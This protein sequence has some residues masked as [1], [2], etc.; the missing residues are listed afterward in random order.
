[1][2]W[3][4]RRAPPYFPYGRYIVLTQLALPIGFLAGTQVAQGD[5]N[6]LGFVLWYG[7]I[8]AAV[9]GLLVL[10]PISFLFSLPGRETLIVLAWA[11]L[12]FEL[13]VVGVILRTHPELSPPFLAL[14]KLA[15]ALTPLWSVGLFFALGRRLLQ[16]LE[17]RHIFRPGLPAHARL[18]L[19]LVLVIAALPLGG[20]AI[21]FWMCARQGLW[22]RYEKCPAA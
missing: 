11:A 20:V 21:P 12:H 3:L 6:G 19:A 7:G 16:P 14:F 22:P 2:G 17:L 13:F 8:A 4:R 1:V 18:V 10:A 5:A 9:A 15:L